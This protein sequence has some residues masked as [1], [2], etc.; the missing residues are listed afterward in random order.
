MAAQVRAIYI[1]RPQAAWA[2]DYLII[3]FLSLDFTFPRHCIVTHASLKIYTLDQV[4]TF[5]VNK[6][7]SLIY[8]QVD[9]VHDS[10]DLSQK[11]VPAIT[12]LAPWWRPQITLGTLCPLHNDI[13]G[14]VYNFPDTAPSDTRLFTVKRGISQQFINI[15]TLIKALL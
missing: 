15:T 14:E 8:S 2:D 9:F 10:N 7:S 12:T 1:T 13:L 5:I 6:L 11:N 3:W 4:N